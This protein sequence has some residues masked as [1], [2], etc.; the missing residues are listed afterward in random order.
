MNC[1]TI[2]GGECFIDKNNSVIIRVIEKH[3]PSG[4]VK[5]RCIRKGIGKYGIKGKLYTYQYWSNDEL[6]NKKFIRIGTE[7]LLHILGNRR[8]E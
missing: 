2:T 8:L 1:N 5:L 7:E 6:V 3:L 4:N